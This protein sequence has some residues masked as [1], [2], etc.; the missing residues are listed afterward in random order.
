MRDL[1]VRRHLRTFQVADLL[2]GSRAYRAVSL[3]AVAVAAVM[4]LSATA[5]QAQTKA[6]KISGEGVGPT[7]LP[8]PGQ[9][10][11]EHWIVGNATHLGLH[12]G[13][14][15]VKTDSAEVDFA[16]GV[17]TGEFG[18][19]DPFVF[20]AANG[21]RLAVHYGRTDVAVPASEPGT[22]VLTILDVLGVT[23]EG[24]PILLVE[25]D[26]LA[27]FVPQPDLC[28]G[29]FAG[30]Q[31]SWIMHAWSEPFILGSDDPVYYGWEGQGELTFQMP[32][33]Q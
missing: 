27:E 23:A 16:N 25:A 3:C 33:E 10:A 31:G 1:V 19:G 29:R 5:A 6:F 32:K 22:F 12:Y 2:R 17:I 21:D 7:G 13:A 14:G 28:T 18:S 26:W 30:I 11:R 15:S 24:D 9:P 4:L 8:L 20:E